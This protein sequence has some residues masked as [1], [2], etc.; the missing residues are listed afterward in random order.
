MH[1]GI[2]R[3]APDQVSANSQ[4]LSNAHEI[5][6]NFPILPPQGAVR[7]SNHFEKWKVL[8]RKPEQENREIR[9][10]AFRLFAFYLSVIP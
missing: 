8:L 5:R 2:A 6:P 9:T 4:G 7:I 10:P 3:A 1:P